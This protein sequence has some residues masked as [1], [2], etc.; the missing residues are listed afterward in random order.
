[1]KNRFGHDETCNCTRCFAHVLGAWFDE[2]GRR[3]ESGRW[4]KFATISYGTTSQP[5]RSGFS[6]SEAWRPSSEFGNRLFDRFVGQLE[7]WLG[8]R[9]DYIVADQYGRMNGRFHQH[10]LLSATGLD[11]YPRRDMESWLC[12]NAGYSRVL[13]YE[14]GAAYYLARFGGRDLYRAEWRLRLGE[15]DARLDT[16][17]KS[18]V[19]VARSA[20]LPSD[21]FHQSLPGRHR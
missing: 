13:P 19:I 14:R 6:M 4:M 18:G 10:A 9:V 15:E 16:R 7:A 17:P 1:M 8:E 5:W 12:R 11:R 3:T 21:F 2:S 20:E